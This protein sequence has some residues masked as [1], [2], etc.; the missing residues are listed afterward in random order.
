MGRRQGVDLPARRT[1]LEQ[2]VEFL[3]L[4]VRTGPPT[5][6]LWDRLPVDV[7]GDLCM[8]TGCTRDRIESA[9]EVVSLIWAAI[10]GKL[11]K[12]KCW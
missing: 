5:L 9:R 7:K 10:I 2:R 8:H 12:I 6:L 1:V 3:Q 4:L 11:G